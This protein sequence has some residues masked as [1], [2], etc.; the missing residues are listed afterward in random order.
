MN[1]IIA[2]QHHDLLIDVDV[3]F[4]TRLAVLEE[5]DADLALVNVALGWAGRISDAPYGVEQSVFKELYALRD[6]NTLKRATQTAA[7]EFVRHWI[8]EA[9]EKIDQMGDGGK[10]SYTINFHPYKLTVEQGQALARV[11]K[12]TIG[13]ELPVHIA[14][15]DN[16]KLSPSFVRTKYDGMFKYDGFDWINANQDAFAVTQCRDTTLYVP[17]LA[18]TLP[19][20]ETMQTLNLK[21]KTIEQ[22]MVITMRPLVNLEFMDVQAFSSILSA[23]M[24]KK[25][26]RERGV[27]LPST[28]PESK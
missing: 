27:I 2:V 11:I 14:N 24:A 5:I 20:N 15:Y 1:S 13:I 25:E 3:L 7:F 16:T 6:L 18:S 26:L 8:L 4:D 19:D 22:D 17:Y 21:T 23:E 9:M 10:L 12:E 28:P